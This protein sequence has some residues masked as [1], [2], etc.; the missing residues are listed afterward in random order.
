MDDNITR[1]EEIGD[2]SVDNSWRG[3]EEDSLYGPIEEMEEKDPKRLHDLS[4]SERDDLNSLLRDGLTKITEKTQFGDFIS[5]VEKNN[6]T[7]EDIINEA[8]RTLA[9]FE[10]ILKAIPNAKKYRNF[11]KCQL[12]N[13]IEQ[14]IGMLSLIHI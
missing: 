14:N 13:I 3:D 1:P 2:T 9:I 12:Y 11:F 7:P 5:A 6:N 10:L 4:D 8:K